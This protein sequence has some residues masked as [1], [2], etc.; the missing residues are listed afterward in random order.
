MAV[1]GIV[2]V[3]VGPDRVT[4]QLVVFVEVH[5][6]VKLSF[7]AVTAL[8]WLNVTVG[9]A[10]QEVPFQVWPAGQLTTILVH[11]PQLL[12]SLDSVIAPASPAELLSAQAR[13]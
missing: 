7:D 13:T 11:P 4:E 10:M 5:D 2:S 9:A 3:G 8:D 12:P 6:A 1:S